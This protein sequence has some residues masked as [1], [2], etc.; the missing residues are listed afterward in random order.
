MDAW[1]GYVAPRERLLA[2]VRDNV[3]N[4]VAL[5]GD[6][7]AGAVTDL[8]DTY[9][10]AD[11]ILAGTE[12]VAPSITSLEL[13][14]PGFLE[15]TRANPHIHHYEPDRRG[16]LVVA[17]DVDEVRADFRYIDDAEDADTGIETASS[18]RLSRGT[19]GATE[20]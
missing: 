3:A 16:Y 14:K 15:R 12:F 18:W 17:F 9:C 20:L 13:L 2:T 8:Y 6:I 19:P 4:F 7:H 10:G 1:D 5:G 11:A